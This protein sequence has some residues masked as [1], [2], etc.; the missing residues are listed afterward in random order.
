MGMTL[1]HGFHV[2]SSFYVQIF[3]K[4]FAL[5]RNILHFEHMLNM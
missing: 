5:F 4:E 1:A 2:G 3:N